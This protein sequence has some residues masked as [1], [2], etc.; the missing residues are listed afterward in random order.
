M[1]HGMHLAGIAA[2]L[3]PEGRS[4]ESQEFDISDSVVRA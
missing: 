3:I 2:G 1:E 4:R